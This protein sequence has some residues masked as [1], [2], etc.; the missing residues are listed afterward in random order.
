MVTNVVT[1][2]ITSTYI[3]TYSLLYTLDTRI[4]ASNI[5]SE[6]T[7][8][9]GLNIYVCVRL[10]SLSMN[11]YLYALICIECPWQKS[12][13]DLLTSLT[14]DFKSLDTKSKFKEALD[15]IT[16]EADKRLPSELSQASSIS[17]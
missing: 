3:A 2:P 8:G 5:Y 16:A 10:E 6:S 15:E 4:C 7:L 17:T 13:L 14:Y 12:K 11:V 9:V 1:S